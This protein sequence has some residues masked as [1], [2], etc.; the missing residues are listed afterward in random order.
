MII[1]LLFVYDGSKA[2]DVVAAVF[3]FFLDQ[4]HT[5]EL[6][7]FINF[8]DSRG[9]KNCKAQHK[10]IYHRRPNNI[11]SADETQPKMQFTKLLC[12]RCSVQLFEKN[13]F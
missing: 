12:C 4:Q 1:I 9:G 3:F 10:N 7:S 6:Q 13:T 8:L 5:I 11:N 2:L